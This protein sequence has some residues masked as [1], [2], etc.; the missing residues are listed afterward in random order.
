MEICVYSLY[1]LEY[2]YIFKVQRMNK[3]MMYNGRRWENGSTSELLVPLA[4]V[5]LVLGIAVGAGIFFYERNQY[6]KLY[7]KAEVRA[8]Q[9]F[10]DKKQP[11]TLEEK[12]EW[13]KSMSVKTGETP[14]EDQLEGFLKS[15]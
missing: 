7:E 2:N 12:T 11:L 1:I 10:G 6:K 15:K 13:Y 5:S 3:S 14:D 9:T 4:V 8:A